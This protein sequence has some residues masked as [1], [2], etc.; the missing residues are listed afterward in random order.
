MFLRYLASP[1]KCRA[2][3]DAAIPTIAGWL[4]VDPIFDPLRDDRRFEDLLK[5]M[6]F[7]E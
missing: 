5:E 2:G 7:P 4:K 6:N 3:L 1:G